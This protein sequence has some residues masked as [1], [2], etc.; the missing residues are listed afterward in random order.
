MITGISDR[1]AFAR[2]RRDA[3]SVSTS[4]LRLRHRPPDDGDSTVV[5]DTRVA[6]AISRK[7]GNA[8]TRNRIRRRIRGS[9]DEFARTAQ[10]PTGDMLFI[11]STGCSN[12]SYHDVRYQVF[13]LMEKLDKSTVL[14]A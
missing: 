9:L 7:V 11:V 13:E 10:L 5:G 4:D 2:L 1:S 8:V 14:P 6:Y 3:T 12:L